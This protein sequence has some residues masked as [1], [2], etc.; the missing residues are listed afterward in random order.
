MNTQKCSTCGQAIVWLLTSA[1]KRMPVDAATVQDGDKEFD[2]ERHTSHFATCP[3][4]Q[5][6]R[7][8]KR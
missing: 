6:H 1:G 4:A 7:R 5:Q 8:A 3:Q 2:R